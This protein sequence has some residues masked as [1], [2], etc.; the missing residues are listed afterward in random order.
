LQIGPRLY[1]I[2]PNKDKNFIKIQFSPSLK[3]K[4]HILS[5]GVQILN[6]V[7]ELEKL[8]NFYFG[9]IFV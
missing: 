1:V 5:F 3:T 4:L 7:V 8:Y 6:K 2:Y 9:H